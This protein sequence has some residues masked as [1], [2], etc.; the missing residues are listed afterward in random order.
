MLRPD[1]RPRIHLSRPGSCYRDRGPRSQDTTSP[2]PRLPR[3]ES[4]SL[5]S[6]I[7]TAPMEGETRTAAE[8]FWGPSGPLRVGA[9]TAGW[10]SIR[11][12]LAPEVPG[13]LFALTF[14]SITKS[15]LQY[16][17]AMHYDTRTAEEVVVD[18]LFLMCKLPFW[19]KSSPV[20]IPVIDSDPDECN[21][22]SLSCAASLLDG[23]F[24]YHTSVSSST[25]HQNF[26]ELGR[27]STRIDRAETVRWPQ[28]RIKERGDG[29]DGSSPNHP[30]MKPNP[31][32]LTLTGEGI[33]DDGKRQ[34]IHIHIHRRTSALP[35]DKGAHRVDIAS[36]EVT[37]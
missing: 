21:P 14:D 30:W 16:H 8:A 10:G 19:H 7:I 11:F 31:C 5:L 17:D 34:W 33:R 25:T 9:R 29:Y 37:L 4:N 1:R 36:V 2:Y 22:Q 6:I 15:P 28:S 23:I 27:I 32:L 12:G 20:A 18:I 3:T 26:V 35:I 24:K 13:N